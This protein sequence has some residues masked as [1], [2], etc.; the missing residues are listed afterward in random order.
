MR[1]TTRS[2]LRRLGA[3]AVATAIA[4]AGVAGPAYADEPAS[5]PSVTATASPTP[6]E[7]S[8]ASTAPT[9]SPT[10]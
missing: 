9:A 2:R 4:L 7:P 5:A 6:A 8:T 3:A 1:V 10:P